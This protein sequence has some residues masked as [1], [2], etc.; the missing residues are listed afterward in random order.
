MDGPI[1]RPHSCRWCASRFPA[2]PRAVDGHALCLQRFDERSVVEGV[3]L[4]I[5]RIA[6]DVEQRTRRAVAVEFGEV[7]VRARA[8]RDAGLD[9]RARGPFALRG[10]LCGVF[11]TGVARMCTLRRPPCLTALWGA[12]K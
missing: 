11:P 4:G 6:N 3:D 1:S 5:D 2:P 12:G 9:Q 8:E 7:G 10:W